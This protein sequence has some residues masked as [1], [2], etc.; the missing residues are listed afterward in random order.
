MIRR[1]HIIT[2]EKSSYGGF[3]LRQKIYLSI[4]MNS[5]VINKYDCIIKLI[6]F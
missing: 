1:T 4:K 5:A 2:Y 3:L 6:G